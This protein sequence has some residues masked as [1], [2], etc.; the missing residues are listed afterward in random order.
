MNCTITD[1][2]ADVTCSWC[3]KKTDCVRTTIESTFFTNSNLCWKCVSKALELVK[4]QESLATAAKP[5]SRPSIPVAQ[6]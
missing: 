2:V 6:E 3:S 5:K 1:V 4:R